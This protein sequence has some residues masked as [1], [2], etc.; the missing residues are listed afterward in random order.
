MVYAQFLPLVHSSDFFSSYATLPHYWLV[1]S[2]SLGLMIRRETFLETFTH[3]LYLFTAS[4]KKCLETCGKQVHGM[5]KIFI[6]T[7]LFHFP[8]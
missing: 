5:S 6:V 1:I 7:S 4:S 8:P 3:S 2:K